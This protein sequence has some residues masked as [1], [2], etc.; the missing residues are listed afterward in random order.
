MNKKDYV[1]VL[2]KLKVLLLKILDQLSLVGTV[3]FDASR[4]GLLGH[5]HMMAIEGKEGLIGKDVSI[6]IA[7][8]ML[9]VN[10]S[11]IVENMDIFIFKKVLHSY[12]YG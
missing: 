3:K 11:H 10:K 8:E 9:L 6:D 5:V 1:S 12:N 4:C 2:G 7:S